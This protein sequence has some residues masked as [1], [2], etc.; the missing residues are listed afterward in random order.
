MDQKTMQ[1]KAYEF[2]MHKEQ[3]K[4]IQMQ[5][6][7]IQKQA[8]EFEQVKQS[9]ADL[10]IM[11]STDHPVNVGSFSTQSKEKVENHALR[12]AFQPSVENAKLS[13]PSLEKERE[14]NNAFIPLGA[15]IFA[16]G[17]ITDS[18]EVLV[19]TGAG[20]AVKKSIDDAIVFLDD[21]IEILTAA[22]KEL[23]SEGK[24]ISKS[25][26]EILNSQSSKASSSQ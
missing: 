20:I 23:D 8:Q 13:K 17:K 9:L 21:K 11:A 1:Q 14:I 5:A 7:Q 4:Q 18:K 24:R 16:S 12:Q 25:A 2:E 19:M 26:Q 6:M 22:F 3:M 15:G 10:K